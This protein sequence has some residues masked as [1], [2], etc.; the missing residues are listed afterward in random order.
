MPRDRLFTMRL[1]AEENARLDTVAKHYGLS[2]SEVLRMILKREADDMREPRP[3]S[4]K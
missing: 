1:N 4:V 3:K 2:A